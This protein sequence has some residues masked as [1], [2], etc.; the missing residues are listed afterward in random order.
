[1]NCNNNCKIC[2]NIVIS[3]SVTVV[4]VDGTDT[5]VIDLPAGSYGNGC[6]YCVVVAQTIPTTA[7]IGMPV[8]FSIGGVTTTV[9]PFTNS[10]CTPVTACGVQKR[11][12]YPV[13]VYTTPTSGVFRSERNICCYPVPNLAAIPAPTVTPAP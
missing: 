6:K 12:R 2:P 1:M 11:T 10:N 8:A 7:T 13:C 9:Y 4:T 5:L 3:T